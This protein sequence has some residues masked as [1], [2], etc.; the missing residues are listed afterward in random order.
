MAIIICCLAVAFFI[1]KLI[2]PDAV[3]PPFSE[4]PRPSQAEGEE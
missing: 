3:D 4:E 2:G 1:A